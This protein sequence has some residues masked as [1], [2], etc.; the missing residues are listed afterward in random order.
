LPPWIVDPRS[1]YALLAVSSITSRIDLAPMASFAE[2]L[3]A[4]VPRV[5]LAAPAPL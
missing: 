4:G 1:L 5:E 2:K 3:L